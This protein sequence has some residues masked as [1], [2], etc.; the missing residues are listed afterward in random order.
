MTPD[1]PD[2]RRVI[3]KLRSDAHVAGVFATQKR[4]REQDELAAVYHE[5]EEAGLMR[6]VHLL[7]QAMNAE[8]RHPNP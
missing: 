1:D 6:A 2:L 4:R 3:H 7:E 5:G 8:T